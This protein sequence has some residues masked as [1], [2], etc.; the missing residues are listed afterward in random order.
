MFS[1]NSDT[2]DLG[3]WRGVPVYLHFGF[4]FTAA[5]LTFP[6]WSRP[7]V[8]SLITA[9]VVAA[10]LFGSILMHE[11]AHA[12]AARRYRIV[13]DRIDI[14]LYGGLVQF[15]HAPWSLKQDVIITLA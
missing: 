3:R 12:E 14:N 9:V 8:T 2:I 15:R 5:V 13:S 11:L 10:V 6:F 1:F 4:L 7:H